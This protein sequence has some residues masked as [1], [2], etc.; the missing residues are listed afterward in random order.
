MR[1]IPYR[2]VGGRTLFLRVSAPAEP[3][4]SPVPVAVFYHGG[5]WVKGDWTQFRPQAD[6]LNA[7]GMLTVLVEYRTAG[8]VAATEDAVAA[9]NAVFEVA[10][11]LGGDPERVVAIGGSAG[12]HLALATAVLDLPGTNPGHRP[13][14]LVL[15]N[16]VTNTSGEFPLGFGR[17]YFDNDDHAL[18]YS[19]LRH[20]GA[21]TPPTLV[22][23][24]T[25]D[26]AVHC[27]NSVEFVE[28]VR[29]HGG[30]AEIVLYP[31]QRHGFFNPRDDDPRAPGDGHDTYFDRTT[32]EMIRFMR[33]AVFE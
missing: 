2:S 17:R 10:P 23:H 13:A 12:G 20:V 26:T 32:R 25:A 27:D 3:P 14:A 24:G 7:L 4:R 15:L 19:P 18:R 8:P 6:R 9:M 22:M 33:I 1:E 16:P 29:L 5:G 21:S 11:D 31:G 28:K 30:H